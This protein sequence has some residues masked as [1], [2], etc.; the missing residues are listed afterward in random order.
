MAQ[1]FNRPTITLNVCLA[2]DDSE[3][4][5]L[6]ALT[7]YSNDALLKAIESKVSEA[8]V[9]EHRPGLS[10]LF[11]SIRSLLGPIVD[12]GNEA[13]KVFHGSHEAISKQMLAMKE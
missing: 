8:L 1:L 10:S 2:L 9:R 13:K 11:D 7:G 12:K 6:Q 4:A 5:A 3:T